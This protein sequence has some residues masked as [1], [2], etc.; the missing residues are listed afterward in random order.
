MSSRPSGESG[1][2]TYNQA[3]YDPAPA[4]HQD[5]KPVSTDPEKALVDF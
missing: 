2:P 1:P 3:M 5:V 4:P